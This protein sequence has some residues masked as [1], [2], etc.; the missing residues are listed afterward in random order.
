M[1]LRQIQDPYYQ[2]FAAQISFYLILSIVP[3]FILIAQV[4]GLFDISMET[5]VQVLEEYTGKR[6]SKMMSSLFR[7]SSGSADDDPAAARSTAVLLIL[8]VPYPVFFPA[9]RFPVTARRFVH[10]TVLPDPV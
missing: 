4:L 2:G 10:E 7:F 8:P 5:V 3:I 6:V 9:P 1:V